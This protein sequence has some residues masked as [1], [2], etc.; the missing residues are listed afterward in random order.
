MNFWMLLSLGLAIRIHES[1]RRGRRAKDWRSSSHIVERY[2]SWTV[3]SRSKVHLVPGRGGYGSPLSRRS[4]ASWLRFNAGLCVITTRVAVADLAQ[5]EGG[6]ALRRDLEHLS[7]EAGEQLLRA[8]EVKGQESE[9][10]APARSSGAI[11]WR[12]H[13]WVAT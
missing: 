8:L 11:A 9:L 6:S 13:C 5:Y 12:S 7:S 10:R 4:C 3:W 1:E 2:W